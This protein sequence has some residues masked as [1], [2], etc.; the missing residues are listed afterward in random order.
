MSGILVSGDK[1]TYAHER[2]EEK[3][4]VAICNDGKYSGWDMDVKL[5]NCMCPLAVG[6]FRMSTLRVTYSRPREEHQLFPMLTK[7]R[8]GARKGEYLSDW[9]VEYETHSHELYIVSL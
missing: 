5:V 3:R 4:H 6:N 7:S 9:E 2:R 8:Q 1:C